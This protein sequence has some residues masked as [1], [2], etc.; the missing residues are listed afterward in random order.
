MSSSRLLQ[1]LLLVLVISTTLVLLWLQ[2]ARETSAA[3]VVV[4][5]LLFCLWIGLRHRRPAAAPIDGAICVVYASQSGQA[6]QLAVKSAEQLIAAG[7]TAQVLSLDQLRPES[8]QGQ[9][10]FI[11]STYGEGEAPDSGAHFEQRL[12]AHADLHDLQ[13]AVLALGDRQYTQFCAFGLR[14]DEA[15]SKRQAQRLFPVL[16]ADQCDPATL[17]QWQQQL[18]YVSGNFDF[19]HWQTEPFQPLTL[20]ERT[21]LN[22]QSTADKVYEVS[23][24]PAQALPDWQAGDLLEISPQQNRNTL[25]ARLKAL[26]LEPD[27]ALPDGRTLLEALLSRQLPDDQHLGLSAEQLQA[28]LPALPLRQYSI[29]STPADGAIQLLVRQM[30]YP[31]GRPGIGS[32]WLCEHAPIGCEIDLRIR[33]NPSF[34]GPADTTPLILIGSGTGLAGLRAH[35]RARPHGSRNWLLFGER[36]EA[37]D[38]FCREELLSYTAN[39]HLSRLDLAFS[40]DQ[41][42]KVYVQHLLRDAADELRK[43]INQ[44]AAIYLC[45]S[46]RGMGH[47]V[48][49]LLQRLLGETELA[50]LQQQGRYRRD[51]Y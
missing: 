33:A 25:N 50:L 35:L 40:R 46:L 51:L 30:Y 38:F 28:A 36:S 44:G 19:N 16:T 37:T 1:H 11:V 23:L 47:D 7:C 6:Q 24:G 34:H 13:Y 12:K 10:L 5:Y 27:Q 8:L 43:W 20:L 41:A 31:D 2:P 22:P 42:N 39:G 45:G 29:A 21:C 26:A 48:H 15:L 49:S 32:G 17:S 9:V 18:A 14:L 3:L 4:S